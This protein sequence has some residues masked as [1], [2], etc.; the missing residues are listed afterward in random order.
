MELLWI[1]FGYLATGAL[2]TSCM[3]GML[4]AEEDNPEFSSKKVWGL[5]FLA[6]L[7]PVLL[8]YA[9]ALWYGVAKWAIRKLFPK[10]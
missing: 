7:W 2:L 3:E 8:A 10:R 4:L 6:V 9:L 5:I 1:L